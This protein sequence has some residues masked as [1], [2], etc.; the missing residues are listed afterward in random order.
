[1]QERE[2]RVDGMTCQHCVMAVHRALDHVP[3]IVVKVV[4]IGAVVFAAD[5]MDHADAQV[6][7]AIR[8]AGYTPAP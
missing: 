6:R 1:M 2:I 5:D 8:D 4:R 7:T 3:G